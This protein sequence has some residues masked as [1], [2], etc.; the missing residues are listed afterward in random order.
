MST[1]SLEIPLLDDGLYEG[2]EIFTVR[3]ETLVEGTLGDMTMASVIII[4][5][6]SESKSTFCT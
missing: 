5:D 2:N 6:E 4:D 1:A 3:I